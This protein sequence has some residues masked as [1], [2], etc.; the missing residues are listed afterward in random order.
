M[1]ESLQAAQ[2]N[3]DRHR[4]CSKRGWT[5]DRAPCSMV[6][7][8]TQ[9]HPN[10]PEYKVA[11]SRHPQKGTSMKESTREPLKSPWKRRKGP[12]GLH[13]AVCPAEQGKR[14][15]QSGHAEGA[16]EGSQKQNEGCGGKT[17]SPGPMEALLTGKAHQVAGTATRAS[18]PED[19]GRLRASQGPQDPT[20]RP[21][22]GEYHSATE[23]SGSLVFTPRVCSER[24][25]THRPHGVPSVSVDRPQ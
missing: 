23:R 6:R 21:P 22:R 12:Q 24:C 17:E 5:E 13:E 1:P 14:G 11:F 19:R 4:P 2:A 15:H 20:T 8:P 18:H 7:S 25:Q 16:P 9:C 3:P 10:H